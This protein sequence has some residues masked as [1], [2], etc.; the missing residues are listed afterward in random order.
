VVE[1]KKVISKIIILTVSLSITHCDSFY[2]NTYTVST[3]DELIYAVEQANQ[4]GDASIILLDGTYQLNDMLYITGDNITFK[5]QSGNR[6]GV[7]IRGD[8]MSGGVSHIFNVVGDDFGVHDMT[9]GCV[10]NHAIQI[11]GNADADRPYISNIRFVD[12]G[13][14]MLKV[15][16]DWS[17]NFSDGGVVENCLF[18]YTAG[19]GP[20]YYIGGID[21]HQGK[22]WVVREN[23]FV[24]IKSPTDELAEH[25]IHFWSDSS[26]TL[27]ERNRILNCDRGIGFGMGESGHTG[28]IIRN[29][30]VYTTMDVG[31]GLEN[32]PHT[33]VYNNTVYTENYANSIEYRFSG[34]YGVEII[35]NLTNGDITSR[36]G[37]SGTIET[38]VTDAEEGWFV[39]VSL[40]DL[41]LSYEVDSVID[42]GQTLP[43]VVND[44]DGE[45]R[46]QGGGYDIGGDEVEFQ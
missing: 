15:S 40:G 25:A 33:L 2:E 32:S 30:F 42:E 38:N 10:V 6:D 8:G 1:V 5:S 7:I 41:H 14:Q 4:S 17:D 39:D 26:G 19:V 44:Y 21:V 20:Q 12:T 46:P 3:V 18:E 23:T 22:D 37:G 27:I 11:Q 29:N 13:E 28:G 9:I 45:S 16:T 36:D 31:I 34:T 24:D 35:N 43:D